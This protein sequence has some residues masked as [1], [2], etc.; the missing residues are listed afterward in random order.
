MRSFLCLLGI[1]TAAQIIGL[2]AE[3]KETKLTLEWL[4]PQNNGAAIEQ[5]NVYQRTVRDNGAREKWNKLNEIKI[6]LV[7]EV[8][9]QLSKGKEYEFVVTAKNRFGESLKE[10]EKI[11]KIVV[12]GGKSIP[13]SLRVK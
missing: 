9:V 3:T 10:E 12:L 6:P 5:Y 11:K 8:V 13:G 7:R 4:E 1:P 2:P